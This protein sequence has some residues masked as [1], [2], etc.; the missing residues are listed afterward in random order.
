MVKTGDE[1]HSL[2]F[3]NKILLNHLI[4]NN[5]NKNNI[6][7]AIILDLFWPVK[8]MSPFGESVTDKLHMMPIWSVSRQPL[9]SEP[10]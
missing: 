9:H 1:G 8:K 10:M 6:T 2:F 5:G 7:A 4:K 3:K